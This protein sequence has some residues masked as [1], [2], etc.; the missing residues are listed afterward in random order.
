MRALFI[1]LLA[2]TLSACGF[3][4]RGAYPLPFSTLHIGLPEMNELHGMIKR[5]VEATSPTRIV[6]TTK[7]AE[8][9]LAILHDQPQKKV[10][11]YDAAGRVREFQLERIFTFRVT[12]AKGALIIAPSTIIIRRDITFSDAQVLAKEAE[13]AMLWRDIQTDL[14]QQ[15]IRR[16]AAAKPA[17]SSATEKAR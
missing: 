4:L 5:N 9:S 14:V 8:A 12:D 6:S 1:V 15:L 10:L 7:E 3:Q 11:S 2:V 16:L 17:A 13:E